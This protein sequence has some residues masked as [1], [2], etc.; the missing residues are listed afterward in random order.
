MYIDVPHKNR[1]QGLSRLYSDFHDSAYTRCINMALKHCEFGQVVCQITL[2]KFNYYCGDPTRIH[3]LAIIGLIDH[4][5]GSA[6]YTKTLPDQGCSTLD[7][8][9]DFLSLRTTDELTATTQ[10]TSFNDTTAS[11]TS[12][13]LNSAGKIVAL[14]SGLFRVG[15]YPGRA[16]QANHQSSEIFQPNDTKQSLMSTLNIESTDLGSAIS[17]I[18]NRAIIGWPLANVFHGGATATILAQASQNLADIEAIE[19][20]LKSL[21]ISYIRPGIGDRK[22][23][24]TPFLIRKGKSASVI[25]AQCHHGDHKVIATSNAIFAE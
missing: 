5:A 13:V 15:S 3:P 24:A 23:I 14:G 7:L 20:R 19:H 11:I 4:S 2:T 9:I 8:K 6:I 17:P 22:L 10:V 25:S 12:Q 1:V 18:D 21:Y 16:L